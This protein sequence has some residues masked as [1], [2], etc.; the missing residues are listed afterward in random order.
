[1][2]NVRT[3]VYNSRLRN[4][5]TESDE[6]AGMEIRTADIHIYYKDSDGRDLKFV[7]GVCNPSPD[8][9]E[10]EILVGEVR[11]G[12]ERICSI[13]LSHDSIISN[14]RM[15]YNFNKHGYIVSAK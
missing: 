13:C 9:M 11:S 6:Y 14:I 2:K 15:R 10:F 12:I 8:K 1:M 3:R 5:A 4:I 7:E